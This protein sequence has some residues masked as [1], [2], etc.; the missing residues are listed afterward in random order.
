M[1]KYFT[2]SVTLIISI[3]QLY[4]QKSDLWTKDKGVMIRYSG[5]ASNQPTPLYIIRVGDRKLQMTDGGN[6]ADSLTLRETLDQINPDWIESVAVLKDKAAI[7]Q[8]GT[9]AQHG[10]I[11]IELKPGILGDMPDE[12]AEKFKR[13]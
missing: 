3:V 4:G 7:D 2:L 10:V 13:Y 6:T 8:F 1:Q 5:P 9:L 12:L 11:L